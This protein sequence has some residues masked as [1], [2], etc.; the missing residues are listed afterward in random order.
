MEALTQNEIVAVEITAMVLILVLVFMYFWARYE[1]RKLRVKFIENE[2]INLL[3]TKSNDEL[4][5]NNREGSAALNNLMQTNNDCIAKL[6]NRINEKN[7]IIDRKNAELMHLMMIIKDMGKK[8]AEIDAVIF[9]AV[10]KRVLNGG[11]QVRING[12][13][14]GKKPE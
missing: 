4:A 11:K 7:E 13:F 14:G 10:D 3:L 5:K 8:Y 12:K 1:L 6:S 9:S 2:A